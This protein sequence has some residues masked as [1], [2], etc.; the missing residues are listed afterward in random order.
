MGSSNETK[1]NNERR[2]YLFLGFDMIYTS[3]KLVY[4]VN[5]EAYNDHCGANFLMAAISSGKRSGLVT[6]SS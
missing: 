6:Y 3:D 5:K 2:F 1:F 4:Y